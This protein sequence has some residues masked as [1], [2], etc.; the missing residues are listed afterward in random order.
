MAKY[1]KY[2]LSFSLVHLLMLSAS[3]CQE[4]GEAGDLFGQWRM[5][6]SDTHY[7]SFSGSIVR[8]HDLHTSQVFGNFQQHGDSLFL[9]FHSIY[10]QPSDTAAVVNLFGPQPIDDIRLKVM[11]L[12]GGHLVLGNGQR[13]WNFCYY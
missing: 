2:L 12:D 13:L 1:F 3:S 4:G 7:I 8:I 11:T 6:N 5:D 10:A 9:Q